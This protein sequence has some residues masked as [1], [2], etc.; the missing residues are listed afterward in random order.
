MSPWMWQV[1]TLSYVWTIVQ[2]IHKIC[3]FYGTWNLCI[4]H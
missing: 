4:I 2:L 3:N 1:E